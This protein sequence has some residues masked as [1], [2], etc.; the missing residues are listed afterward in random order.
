[1]LELF[2]YIF[3]RLDVRLG[4]STVKGEQKSTLLPHNI[5]AWYSLGSVLLVIFA[6]QIVTGLLLMIYYVADADKAFDTVSFIMEGI[7]LG[8]LVRLVH[9]VGSSTMITV[10]LLH[11]LSVLFMGG[12]KSPRELH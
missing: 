10:L 8:R 9:A 6:L 5:N 2:R 3:R 7:P 12:Y 4:L 1:M 11:L